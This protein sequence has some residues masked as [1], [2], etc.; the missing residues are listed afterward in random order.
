MRA[1]G[2]GFAIAALI[3]TIP[4]TTPVAEAKTVT[5]EVIFGT[6]NTNRGFTVAEGINEGAGIELG[7]RAKLRY[8]S[9]NSCVENGNVV[10]CPNDAL[11]V[12]IIQQPLGNYTNGLKR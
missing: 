8:D 5:P 9:S 3:V 4:W 11:D 1:N 7:L 12:G 10:G 2:S 6:G